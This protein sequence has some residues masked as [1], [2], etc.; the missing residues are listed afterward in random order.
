M[1]SVEVFTDSTQ[2]ECTEV[3]SANVRGIL[4][5]GIEIEGSVDGYLRKM[6]SIA[7]FK[8][9]L[10]M[11]VMGTRIEGELHPQ[12]KPELRNT[13]INNF[14]HRVR[15]DGTLR[16]NRKGEVR[17]V[18]VLGVSRLT[19]E[20]RFKS[21]EDISGIYDITGGLEAEDYLRRLRNAE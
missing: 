11:P 18:Q 15:L 1:Q 9:A 21:A 14:E 8:F 3:I 10:W 19:E 6:D 16:T 2:F 17:S 4:R 13:I 5:P 12:A 20:A 7:G